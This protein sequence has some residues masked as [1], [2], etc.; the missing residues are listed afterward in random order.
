MANLQEVSVQ[1]LLDELLNR[2]EAEMIRLQANIEAQEHEK[3]AVLQELDEVL[4]RLASST[5]EQGRIDRGGA[6][7][8][9]KETNH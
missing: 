2:V 7:T 6:K 3:Q 4:R 1:E 8:T 9:S 5:K